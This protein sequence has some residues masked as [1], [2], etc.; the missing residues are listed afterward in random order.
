MTGAR[1]RKLPVTG[2]QGL[3]SRLSNFLGLRPPRRRQ[4]TALDRQRYRDGVF[5]GK[6][7]TI[8]DIEM[9]ARKAGFRALLNLNT[10][11]EPGQILSP[12]VEATW[13]HTFEMQHERVSIDSRVL[14]SEWVDKFLETLQEIAKPVYVHSLLGRR[15]AALMTI[16][17]ALECRISGNE[18]LAEARALGIDCALEQLQRFTASE[19]DR[20]S[21]SFG[22]ANARR[23]TQGSAPPE[24]EIEDVS[25]SFDKVA[26]KAC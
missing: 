26:R 18:A 5:L 6:S 13:A 22:P 1:A 8:R 23:L 20:R 4:R 9:L 15:A 3:I 17:L 25:A 7:P 21:D 11:G 10:E 14:R 24:G 2:S 19:V 12:N 16:H